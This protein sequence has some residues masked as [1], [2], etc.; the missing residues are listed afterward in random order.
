[1][2][3]AGAGDEVFTAEELSLYNGVEPAKPVYLALRGV[4]FDVTA[5]K[6]FYGP[7]ARTR[8]GIICGCV[9]SWMDVMQVQMHVLAALQ[10]GRMKHL[11]VGNAR[12][13]SPS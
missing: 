9:Q 13:L 10:E 6:D 8:S 4:V 1:M 5:G 11:P 7:G 3:E 2:A 12:E